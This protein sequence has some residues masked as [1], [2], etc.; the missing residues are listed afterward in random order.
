[1]DF[2][3][4]FAGTPGFDELPH[5]HRITKRHAVLRIPLRR[6]PVLCHD[7]TITPAKKNQN[8]TPEKMPLTKI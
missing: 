5:G 3:Q 8:N 2:T 6:K 1:D 7:I 4:P